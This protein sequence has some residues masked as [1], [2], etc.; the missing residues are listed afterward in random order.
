MEAKKMKRNSEKKC[1][2]RFISQRSEKSFLMRKLTKYE[3][4]KYLKGKKQ[5]K[6]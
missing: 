4:K 1:L 6:K 2:F 5:A 3:A